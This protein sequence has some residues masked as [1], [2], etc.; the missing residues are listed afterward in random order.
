M[1]GDDGHVAVLRKLKR[2]KYITYRT[3]RNYSIMSL[4]YAISY[5]ISSGI[6][7]KEYKVGKEMRYKIE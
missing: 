4:D 2:N 6:K 5:L 3:M 1:Y 7:I